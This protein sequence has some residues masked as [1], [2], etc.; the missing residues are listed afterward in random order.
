[1][2]HFQWVKLDN[3]E[4]EVVKVVNEGVVPVGINSIITVGLVTE[5]GPVVHPP[6]EVPIKQI[7]QR[8][9]IV[10]ECTV[11]KAE[12]V[13][14]KKVY[15]AFDP[16]Y[17]IEN[18]S[19]EGS[20]RNNDCGIVALAN[21]AQIPYHEARMLCFRHG[22]SSTK[23][24]SHGFLEVILE[25]LG[26]EYAPRDRFN[27]WCVKDLQERS[28]DFQGVYLVYVKNHVMPMI[29]GVLYNVGFSQYD[30]IL[31]VNELRPLIPCKI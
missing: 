29:N 1:M 21:V 19:Y 31:E 12:V 7:K 23:G 18:F 16:P 9:A 11:E 3:L 26:F 14:N 2:S 8:T 27:H 22:W 13:E 10:E 5:W 25:K 15:A 6:I 30:T 24:I 4:W 17:H 28:L 20:Q